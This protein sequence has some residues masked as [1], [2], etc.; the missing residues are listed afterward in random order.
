MSVDAGVDSKVIAVVQP[1]RLPSGRGDSRLEVNQRHLFDRGRQIARLLCPNTQGNGCPASR[2][3][4]ERHP[5]CRASDRVRRCGGHCPVSEVA[6]ESQFWSRPAR[7]TNEPSPKLLTG[8]PANLKRRIPVLVS[9]CPLSKK[10]DQLSSGMTARCFGK[11]MAAT[12]ST[13]LARAAKPN[14]ISRR[15]ECRAALR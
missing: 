13:P 5:S 14:R 1:Q 4:Q 9:V 15:P 10:T 2:G 11:P 8:I 6:G 12:L 7:Q 3:A